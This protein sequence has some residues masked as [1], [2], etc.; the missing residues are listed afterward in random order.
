MT[1]VAPARILGMEDKIGTLRVGAEADVTVL[2]LLEGDWLFR[3]V[4][5]ATACSK[6]A[7]APRFAL[8]AGEVMPLDYGPRPWGWAPESR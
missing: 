7:L 4:T 3:D 8:K 1:T 5:G 6:L 2:E